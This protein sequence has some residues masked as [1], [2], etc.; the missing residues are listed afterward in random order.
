[1]G[2][3]MAMIDEVTGKV[4]KDGER[5]DKMYHEYFEWCDET[6]KNTGFA[7]DDATKESEKLEAQIGELTSD[8][9]VATSKIEELAGAIAKAEKELE[10]ARTIRTKE[11]EDF[12]ASEKELSDAISAL[13]RAIGI[14]EKEM[15]KNPAS[16]AQVDTSNIAG[17]LQAFSAVLEAS[18][19]STSDM[20]NLLAL[21]QSQST[22]KNSDD[23]ELGEPAAATYKTHS[24]GIF[25]VLEDMKEK[26][27][28]QLSTLRKEEVNTK[29]N[30]NMLKQ[31]LEAQKDADNGDMKETKSGRSSAEEDK[32]TAEGDLKMTKK[33]LAASTK[34]LATVRST[35]IQV[36]AD[37]EA[38][39][40]ARKEELAVI[41]QAKKIL[42]DTSKGAVS[43]TYSFIQTAVQMQSSADLAVTEVVDSVK[44]LAKQEHSAALAQL[45]SR[46]GAVVRYGG[47]NDPFGKIKGLIMDMI[48]KLEKEAG[49]EATEK[50]Y[51]DEQIAKTEF[52]KGELEDDIAKYTG[53]IDKAASKS[54]QL[55]SEI[56]TLQ[57]ELAALATEQATMD[58]MRK[59]QNDEFSIAKA[60]LELGLA[61][62]RKALGLLRD[63]YGGASMLQDD[64]K[65]G[66]FMQQPAAPEQFSK[67]SGAGGS[68]IDIL[69]VCE[70]DFA[71]NLAK[72][73][74]QEAD[75]LAEYEKV[76]QENAVSKATKE[77]DVKYKTQEA[78]S[79]DST[80]TEYSGDRDGA[81]DELSAVLTYYDKIKERCIAKPET[82]EERQRRRAAEIKGLKTALSI[83]ENE[84]AAFLQRKNHGR[85]F[86]GTLSAQ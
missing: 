33:E 57:S 55:K 36:G 60:D 76:S 2:A 8:I 48:T 66:A 49:A 61:G 27:E 77:Q 34:Q 51:C 68:I 80:V 13:T 11:E 74:A 82:Y 38:N 30:Y 15:A 1:M 84:T 67:S 23:D 83:L 14:L 6:N 62:V 46:I 47:S 69:E 59:E 9:T 78:K 81:N 63:Y 43:Q 41:A 54:A 85:R 19:I 21:V 26:A 86:R 52:K 12:L 39:V 79:M 32:A 64:A 53:K 16:F 37:H 22:A 73:E 50:A 7:I 40:A 24:S 58:K 75:S 5:E 3:V 31:S 4:M 28:T 20:S 44:R 42:S 35:C 10:D 71:T 65:L 56:K 25:D 72:E 18:S 29:Q 70:S 17:T 45:A